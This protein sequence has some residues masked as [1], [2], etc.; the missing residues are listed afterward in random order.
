MYCSFFLEGIILPFP[1]DPYI[2][3]LVMEKKH[4]WLKI[5]LIAL[6]IN[7]FAA[8]CTYM[9]GKY[10]YINYLESM[11]QKMSYGT[12]FQ[13]LLNSYAK[14]GNYYFVTI[15]AAFSPF[16]FKIVSLVN[17]F[18]AINLLGF[19]FVA[20]ITRFVRFGMVGFLTYKLEHKASKLIKKIDKITSYFIVLSVFASLCYILFIIYIIQT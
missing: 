17:G 20:S 13:S 9:I 2:A 6:T 14:N 19:L 4:K 3:I 7:M 5:V 15:F 8:F 1:I 18:V 12:S 10:F 16:P 11:I